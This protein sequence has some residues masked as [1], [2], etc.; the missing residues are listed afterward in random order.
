MKNT[1]LKKKKKNKK[2]R[3]GLGCREYLKK[4]RIRILPSFFAGDLCLYEKRKKWYR[5]TDRKMLGE[6]LSSF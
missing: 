5:E 6:Q 1:K 2:K 4:K 3:K